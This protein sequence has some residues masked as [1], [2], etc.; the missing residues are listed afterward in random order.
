MP[1]ALPATQIRRVR[2]GMLCIRI[3]AKLAM[4]GRRLIDV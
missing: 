4:I 1:A 2:L 3:S